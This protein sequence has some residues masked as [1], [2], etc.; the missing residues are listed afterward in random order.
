MLALGL[1]AAQQAQACSVYAGTNAQRRAEQARDFQ[2]ADLTFIAQVA[3]IDVS[4]DGESNI[5]SY[6]PVELISDRG[7][8]PDTFSI[9]ES[10]CFSA[11]RI[12]EMH[13]ILLRSADMSDLTGQTV[14]ILGAY[15]VSDI[16][17][18]ALRRRVDRALQRAN[19]E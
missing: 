13:V 1:F 18:R 14:P 9:S 4:D 11:P 15:E 12:G 2:Q 8:L 16:L 5:I 7:A 6:Q 3:A 10:S 19:I 17:H